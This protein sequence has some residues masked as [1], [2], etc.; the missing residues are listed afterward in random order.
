[1]SAIG[2]IIDGLLFDKTGRTRQNVC[3]IGAASIA[4]LGVGGG[5]IDPPSGQPP[6]D[7]LIGWEVKVGWTPETGWF[8]AIV[9]KD[10]TLVPTP[11]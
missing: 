10:D 11:S 2:V 9:P 8:V 1:M 5:P 3:L 4:G 7:D 6:P